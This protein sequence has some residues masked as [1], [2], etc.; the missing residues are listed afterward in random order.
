MG[1]QNNGSCQK[2]IKP[3]AKNNK[4]SADNLGLNQNKKEVQRVEMS[5]KATKRSQNL[6]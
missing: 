4:I 6:I 3:Q 2:K 5:T 1:D